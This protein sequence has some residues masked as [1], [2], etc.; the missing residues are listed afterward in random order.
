MLGLVSRPV[1]PSSLMR[2]IWKTANFLTLACAI[3]PLVTS[4]CNTR[5]STGLFLVIATDLYTT[6]PS[7]IQIEFGRDIF[8][9]YMIPVGISSALAHGHAQRADAGL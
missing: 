9:I 3:W 4:C 2:Y 5:L 1:L 8:N 6:L 7:A